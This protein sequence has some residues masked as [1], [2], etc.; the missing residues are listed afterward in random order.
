MSAEEEKKNEATQEATKEAE[1]APAASSD[2]AGDRPAAD[3]AP[4][5]KI[6]DKDE[7]KTAEEDEEI[8]IKEYVFLF[9]FSLRNTYLSFPFHLCVVVLCLGRGG[10]SLVWA[11]QTKLP[12]TLHPSM[13]GV[14]GRI[15]FG[16]VLYCV[17]CVGCWVLCLFCCVLLC[18]VVFCCVRLCS[19]VFCCVLLCSVVFCMISILCEE[20]G[21]L[22]NTGDCGLC[23]GREFEMWELV[24]IIVLC[25]LCLFLLKPFFPLRLPFIFLP[26]NLYFQAC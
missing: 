19:V 25:V 8:I 12:Q 21:R 10:G 2:E 3:G 23:L 18:S 6:L 20:T 4:L 9:C 5:V 11:S 15:V 14:S 24:F 17:G 13:G 26:S 22:I 7:L 16:F 1:E